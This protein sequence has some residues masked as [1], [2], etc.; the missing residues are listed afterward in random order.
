M[1]PVKVLCVGGSDSSGGA[2]IQADLKA[3]SA[4]GCYG[5]SVITAVTAQNTK[6]VHGVYPVS[7]KFVGQQLDDVLNDIGADS[8]KTGM[9]LTAGVVQE[10]AK[11]IKKYG[12]TKVVVDPVMI[13]KGGRFLMQDKAREVM[14]NNL[15]PLA[16][17]FTPNI[18][19]AEKLARM[20]I[21]SVAAMKRAAVK[22]H[23]MGVKNVLIKGGHLQ[24]SMRT[25][26][27]DILYNGSYYEFSSPRID[28]PNTHGTGCSYAS[29]LASALAQ[30]KNIVDAAR[31]AK[32]MVTAAIE[33]ALILGKGY[34]SVNIF[35]KNILTKK[36][37]TKNSAR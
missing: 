37:Q 15:L 18:P 21:T 11:K 2:G 28:S 4:C 20:K 32:I 25:V 7:P 12:L 27:I 16:L 24:G 14:V 33:N 34:G 26:V 23:E 36:K 19:E 8:V 35:G 31:Q 6:G 3:V 30:N 13:A 29:V 10:V 5:L 17:V 1:E 9:L 22:I